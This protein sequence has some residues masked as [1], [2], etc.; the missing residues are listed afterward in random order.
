MPYKDYYLDLDPTYKDENGDPLL[1]ITWDYSDNDRELH[2][3]LQEKHVEILEKMGAT[4]II[5]VP[6]AEHFTGVLYFQHNGGGAIMGSDPNTSAVNKYLQMWD[7]ENLFVCGSSAFPH[8]G[9][10]N[11][12]TTAAA[13]TYHATEGMIK[14]LKEGGGL[15]VK[16]NSQKEFA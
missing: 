11:P 13:L 14:Y 4:H 1:R 8:F 15:L 3:F 6:G 2:K 9:V 12:T 10:T 16:G 5:P 7:C